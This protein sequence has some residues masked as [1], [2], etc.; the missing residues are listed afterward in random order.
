M[1]GI[2]DYD[3][4]PF[5]IEFGD[6]DFSIPERQRPRFYSP[7]VMPRRA[8]PRRTPT[9]FDFGDRGVFNFP[10]AP[11]Y[12][13]APTGSSDFY[14]DFGQF[15]SSE[16][17]ARE[18]QRPLIDPRTGALIPSQYA[19]AYMGPRSLIEETGEGMYIDPVL[20]GLEPE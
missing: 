17:L 19:P 15:I 16:G 7:P 3:M 6:I 5:G 8:P 9:P 1:L 13:A 14:R 18:L 11:D 12:G 20:A 2:P 10:G 4:D